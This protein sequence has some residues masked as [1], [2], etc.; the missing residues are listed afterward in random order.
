MR[1]RLLRLAIRLLPEEFRAS[2][3]RELEITAR[4]EG[5]AGTIIDVL[6]RA[7]GLHWDI[8]QRDGRLALRTLS[9]R[10]MGTAAVTVTLALGIGANVAMVAVMDTVVWSPL[11]Y[12]E[13]GRLLV[14]QEQRRGEAP[15]NLGYLTFSD[16]KDRVQSV[17][18]MVA[19]TQS[20]ATLTAPNL[21][22][23]R[24]SAMRVSHEYFAMVGASPAL[25]R[26][27][28]PAEDAPG[29]ARR[30]VILSDALWRRRFQA[31]PGVVGRLLDI[32]GTPFRIVGVMPREFSDLVAARLYNGA[33]LWTPLGYD[34]AAAFACRTCRHLRVFGRLAP[35]ATEAQ[36]QR[37]LAE[38]MAAIERE[39]PSEYDNATIATHSLP[40]LF[41]GPVRPVLVALWAGVGL[42]WLVACGNVAHLLL[43]RASERVQEVAVRTALGVT[44]GRLIRQFLTETW[45]LALAG[46][47][48]GVGLAWAV[49]QL[50]AINGP[51]QIP[52]LADVAITPAVLAIAA[53]LVAA[54]GVLIAL[55]PISQVLRSSRSLRLGSGA[56]G[57]DS[58]AAWRSRH[59]LVS[60]N[61]AFAVLLLVGSGLLVRSLSGLLSVAPGFTPSGLLTFEVWASGE[62]FRTG[63]PA[64]QIG[65][66][67]RYY[68]DLLTRLRAIPGVTHAAATTTLPL[69]GNVDGYGFHIEGRPAANP[70]AAPSA[71][72]FAVTPE[73]FETMGIR[74]VSGRL[75]TAQDQ[76]AGEAVVVIN[77]TAARTLFGGDDPIGMRVM[78]GPPS[79]RPR[80]VVGIANDVAHHGLDAEVGPQV[81]VPHAQWAWAETAMA[82]VVRT[83]GTPA[84]LAGPAREAARALDRHQP[85]TRVRTYDA[86]IGG[87]TGTRRFAA[88]LLTVFG[89]CSLAL[90]IVGLYGSVG[91]MVAQRRRELGLRLALGAPRGGIR[92]LVLS[93]GLQPVALGLLAGLALASL[94]TGALSSLLFEVTPL[95]LPTFSS[96]AAALLVCA[97]LACLIPAR[98]ATRI[99]PAVTLR[100]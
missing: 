4:T 94:S 43:L 56:R 61:V 21:D 30:V 5:A 7:P 52:R 38:T 78:L 55:A 8:L 87:T 14:I 74:A 9:A 51:E 16:L 17:Q 1:P 80:T 18:P 26:V 12:H 23:E 57:T 75:L 72:R 22:A 33:E 63:E 31:D 70:E 28:L 44:R 40:D 93:Q 3:G 62:R 11:P 53:A 69:G 45:L 68:D 79:A 41:L 82:V 77:Q 59:V 6:R 48:A 32:S 95:D 96:A 24:V 84:A 25:G 35:G 85:I 83:T 13:A 91:V 81:Y 73:Y 89:L 98:R 88:T 42:L 99:D 76:Q 58:R 60:A 67:V 27:F 64:D 2:Y 49:L 34:P 37:E 15:T 86:I 65:A 46:G 66:A 50:V 90:A 19:A 20:T 29:E 47:I 92:R 10:P 39:H 97:T 100:E 36:A 54:S 71:D